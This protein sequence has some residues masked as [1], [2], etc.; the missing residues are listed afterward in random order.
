M[1]AI[2]PTVLSVFLLSS[3]VTIPKALGIN[4]SA[5]YL[6]EED[7]QMMES[8]IRDIHH[9]YGHHAHLDIPKVELVPSVALA[10]KKV[11]LFQPGENK[12]FIDREI[13]NFVNQEESR[14]KHKQTIYTFILGHE[15]GHYYQ[16]RHSRYQSI[17]PCADRK[18]KLSKREVEVERDA[19]LFAVFSAYRL[20]FPIIKEV[21][22]GLMDEIYSYFEIGAYPTTNPELTNRKTMVLEVIEKAD[23]LFHLFQF[24]NFM[25]ADKN[26]EAASEIYKILQSAYPSLEFFNNYGVLCL[27]AFLDQIPA[28]ER[29]FYPIEI[30]I[31]SDLTNIR[32]TPLRLNQGYMQSMASFGARDQSKG[33]L[34]DTAVYYFELA[35]SLGLE[36]NYRF[37]RD[38]NYNLAI[39]QLFKGKIDSAKQRIAQSTKQRDRNG[40]KLLMDALIAAHSNDGVAAIDLFQ[41]VLNNRISDPIIKNIAKANLL[42]VGQKVER[43]P[44][45]SIPNLN[46]LVKMD[47]FLKPGYELRK[48]KTDWQLS[49]GYEAGWV[50]GNN[51]GETTYLLRKSGKIVYSVQLIG[52][53]NLPINENAYFTW[54]GK[55]YSV[56]KYNN[57]Y[58]VI[59]FYDDRLALIG[60]SKTHF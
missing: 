32:T 33:A 49:E 35:L 59:R 34:L 46:N 10:D 24:A 19:D 51:K 44:D 3:V 26:Y 14:T 22:P 47:S 60:V 42:K 28:E 20:G 40:K 58:N 53:N 48:L 4:E 5:P 8:V 6:F 56:E 37:N 38:L 41:K 12:I 9:L 30:I 11:A 2:I 39:A 52:Q 45:N 15:M 57:Y 36:S 16:F 50:N 13:I 7:K 43:L 27:L 21:I 25:I 23:S 54:I 18:D 29:L 17:V 55:N 1:K 31:D